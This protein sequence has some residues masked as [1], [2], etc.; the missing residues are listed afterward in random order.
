MLNLDNTV[1]KWYAETEKAILFVAPSRAMRGAW[2]LTIVDKP[3]DFKIMISLELTYAS[4]C[5]ALDMELAYYYDN[6]TVKTLSASLY[7]YFYSDE[8]VKAIRTKYNS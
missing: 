7:D 2:C 5:A 1:Y 8:V 4:A 6:K 3:T